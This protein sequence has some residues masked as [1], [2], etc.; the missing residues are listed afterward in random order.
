MNLFISSNNKEDISG[1]EIDFSK[2]SKELNKMMIIKDYVP[3]IVSDNKVTINE[4]NKLSNFE[5]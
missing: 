2:L 3:E 5:V 1:M 4:I